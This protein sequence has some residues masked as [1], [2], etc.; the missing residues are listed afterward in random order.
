MDTRRL[1]ETSDISLFRQL[2][3]RWFEWTVFHDELPTTTP[4]PYL[5][6]S[7]E[8]RTENEAEKEKAVEK[9]VF[10]SWR[11]K[12]VVFECS[13]VDPEKNVDESR[14]AIV[15]KTQYG[16]F[17]NLD[18]DLMGYT[19]EDLVKHEFK[20]SVEYCICFCFSSQSSD[21]RNF[22]LFS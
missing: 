9:H 10:H 16:Y 15:W 12:D 18:R 11:L 20:I 6:S 21:N 5:M 4:Y 17:A 1:E 8:K 19:Q 22:V 13:S 14:A 7:A 3:K 2:S